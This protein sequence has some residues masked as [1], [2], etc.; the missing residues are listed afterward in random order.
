MQ[1]P[2]ADL[3]HAPPYVVTCVVSD[4]GAREGHS[5][6]VAIETR[7]PDGGQT[8]WTS[9]QVIAAI[10]S[11]ERFVVG[12]DGDG[13]EGLLQPATCPSCSAATL[14]AAPVPS[15]HPAPEAGAVK[16]LS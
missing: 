14:M 11:G 12:E 10:E 5:H 9:V 4:A 7:D 3:N 1:L 15:C 13:S 6:V 16:P 8:R 2:H